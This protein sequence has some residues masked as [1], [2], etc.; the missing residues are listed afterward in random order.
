MPT[1]ADGVPVPGND[2]AATILK[3]PLPAPNNTEIKEWESVAA[4]LHAQGTVPARYNKADPAG[5]IPRR[6]ICM[7]ANSTAATGGNCSK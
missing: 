5:A 7:G 3:R 1:L 6:A 4:Y 2:P